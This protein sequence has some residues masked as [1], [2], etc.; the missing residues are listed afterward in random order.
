ME[1]MPIVLF[2]YSGDDWSVENPFAEKP[3]HDARYGEFYTRAKTDYGLQIVRSCIDWYADG[4]WSKYWSYSGSEWVKHDTEIRP[5]LIIDKSTFY[6][7]TYEQF[8]SM[9]QHAILINPWEIKTITSDKMITSVVL[10][11][12]GPQ[13]SVVYTT[14]QLQAAVKRFASAEVV[15]K[16]QYGLGGAGV[17]IL[18]R[19]AAQ[20]REIDAPHV[21]QPFIDSSHGITGIVD[22][23]H[24]FRVVLMGNEI[25]FAYV[26][27]PAPGSKLCNLTQGGKAIYVPLGAIPP[28]VLT[29]V[30]QV[31]GRF[32]GFS[33]SLYS[34]DFLFDE[35]QRPWIIEMNDMPGFGY[36]DS[37][38]EL[39]NAAFEAHLSYYSS[40]VKV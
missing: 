40:L 16:P 19:A 13:T 9:E 14:A 6:F 5:D 22:G 2:L 10:A 39:K 30:D 25:V 20:E 33:R 15:V 18:T 7:H 12:H 1:K 34:L 4:A 35:Q 26:R 27:T 38:P 24:D 36:P 11:E 17:E 8:K 28:T 21:I 37:V 3:T 29:I 32:Q 23:Y 31:R